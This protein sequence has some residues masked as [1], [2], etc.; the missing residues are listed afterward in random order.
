MPSNVAEGHARRKPK[1][2]LNHVRIALG[3]VAE[4]ETCML[5]AR[6]R[7]YVS[8]ERFQT[9]MDAATRSQ[10]LL[11]GLARSIRRRAALENSAI[12]LSLVLGS[13]AT[14]VGVFA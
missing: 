13:V 4:L 6:K 1:V 2:F 11:Y 5:I 10:Q 7:E 12:A 8:Q 14:D 9:T 3:S